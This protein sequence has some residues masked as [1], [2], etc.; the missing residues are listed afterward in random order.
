MILLAA[1]LNASATLFVR[2]DQPANG[3]T[4]VGGST[5]VISWSGDIDPNC[6]IEEWE[7][8]LSV[9]GGRYYSV[10]IT[11]HLDISIREFR[12]VV[13]NVGSR[14]ARLMLR[15][16]NEESEQAIELPLS[17]RIETGALRSVATDSVE[18]LGEPARPGDPGVMEW[19]EGDRSGDHL[20]VVTAS[21]PA[22]APSISLAAGHWSVG[23]SNDFGASGAQPQS[24]DRICARPAR[25]HGARRLALAPDIILHGCRFNI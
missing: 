24:A 13:P 19:A 4:L 21:I 5:A 16:G 15:L 23:E 3:T 25:P 22:I 18:A 10:R 17:L 8:F 12:W 6:Q 1:P 11:P 9:D 14:D 20:R 2:I 7:A